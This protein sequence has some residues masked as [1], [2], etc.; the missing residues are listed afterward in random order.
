MLSAWDIKINYIQNGSYCL[1]LFV[2]WFV[3]GRGGWKASWTRH[4]YRQSKTQYTKCC[5][6]HMGKYCWSQGTKWYPH[7]G[8]SKG[9][10]QRR[11]CCL[12]HPWHLHQLVP[13]PFLLLSRKLFFP[14]H[15]DTMKYL[16]FL[17][18]KKSMLFGIPL[19]GASNLAASLLPT[20]LCTISFLHSGLQPSCSS[21]RLPN[22]LTVLMW[23]SLHRIPSSNFST[24]PNSLLFQC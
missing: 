22:I 7:L 5:C 23:Y 17:S 4:R 3:L 24:Y 21:H 20:L 13:I 11:W 12:S 16:Q 9:D 6:R 18:N 14:L 2:V 19:R 1:Q 10:S 15:F 8:D